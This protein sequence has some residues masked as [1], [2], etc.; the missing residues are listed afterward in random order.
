MLAD[1]AEG[2]RL[3][4]QQERLTRLPESGG[5]FRA[6]CRVRVEG[7]LTAPVL[8]GAV[9]KVVRRHEILRT[10]FA[11]L[12][13]MTLPLQ[14][15][16]EEAAFDLRVVDL[17]GR[18]P[19]G[20]EEALDELL[21]EVRSL[22][23]DR[24]RGPA[25]HVTLASLA[26][27]RHTL[28]FLLPALCADRMSMRN[29]V[30]EIAHTLQRADEKA[31]PVQYAD[32]A[33]AFANLLEAEETAAGR[34]FWR[35][36]ERPPEMDLGVGRLPGEGP[37]EKTWSFTPKPYFFAVGRRLWERL[38]DVAERFTA[39]REA[40]LVA[41]W[42]TLLWR[43]SGGD[44]ATVG[45]AFD[46]RTFAGLD[47]A[48]GLFTRDL[49]LVGDL[50]P[51]LAFETVVRRVAAGLA[52]LAE[53]QDFYA[54]E[55][56]GASDC[57]FELAAERAPLHAGERVFTLDCEEI[58]TGPF[59]LRLV[60]R[61]GILGLAAELWYDAG[62]FSSAEAERLAARWTRLLEGLVESPG[63]TIDEVE[64]VGEAERRW[65]LT[66]LNDTHVVWSGATGLHG[67]VAEQAER[68]PER[69]ALVCEGRNLS[70]GALAA[71]AR[72]L[73]GHLR[74]LGVLP[75]TK[76]GICLERSLEMVISLLAVLEAGGAYVPLDPD[77]PVER[78]AMIV[79]DSACP[80][81]IGD[82]PLT[83]R[84]PESGARTLFLERNRPAFAG[85]LVP[86]PVGPEIDPNALA[87][88][89]YTSGS[90]GKPKGV[91]V[92]HRAIVNRLRWMT[93]EFPLLA[94][95]RV[96]Q[97]TPF[98]FD[99][100]IWEIFSPLL[101]G[102]VA[103]LAR[104]GGHQETGYLAGLAAREEVT[105][106]QMVPPQLRVFLDEPAVE[107]CLALRRVFCGGDVLT[108]ALR[109]QC[110][111]R[112]GA[113][114]QNLYGPTEAAIDASFWVCRRGDTEAAVPIGRPLANVHLY[115]LDGR[116]EPVPFGIPGELYI[117]GTGLARGYLG[118]PD[119]TAERFLPDPFGVVPGGRLYSSGDFGRYRSDGALEFL[120]RGDGQVKIRGVRIEMGE[121]EA[122]LCRHPGVRAAVVL[123]REEI[124]GEKRLVA[125]VVPRA[126]AAPTA[127]EMRGFLRRVLPEAALPAQLVRLRAL[128]LLPNGKLDR[129]ALPV[130]EAAAGTLAVAP[131]TPVEDLLA[132]VWCE[133]LRLPA[134]GVEDNFFDLGGHSL[135]AT[136]LSSRLRHVLGVEVSMRQLFE[137][138]TVAELAILFEQTRRG[139]AQTVPPLRPGVRT[140]DVPLS[141]AQQRLWFL[142][143]LEP[144]NPAYNIPSALNAVGALDPVVLDAAFREVVRRHEVLRTS[145]PAAAGE[146]RQAV[147]AEQPLAL[148]V[149]DLRGLAERGRRDREA[150]RLTAEEAGL[151]F[152][153]ARGPLARVRLLRLAAEEQR[154]LVTLHHIVGDAW[155]STV[156]SRELATLY[157]AFAAGRPSPLPELP[158]QYADF[159]IWQREWLRGEVLEAQLR[160]WKERLD[161]APTLLE[162]PAD[163]PRPEVPSARGGH[164][165]L[166]LSRDLTDALKALGRRESV[167]LFMITLAAYRLLLHFATGRDDVVVGTD[168]ANRN[169][170]ETEGLIGFFINQLVLRTDLG[171]NPT[172]RELLAREREV[173]LDAYA[174][175]DL[176]FEK[177]IDL[178]NIDRNLKHPPLF[179][180]KLFFQNVPT[181]KVELPGLTLTSVATDSDAAKL[182][183][184]LAFWET[185]EGLVG[186]AN[187]S[188]D[189]FDGATIE[190]LLGQL[191]ALLAAMVA[192]PEARIGDLRRVYTGIEK[193]RLLMESDERLKFDLKQF[194]SIKPKA[195]NLG[196]GEPVERTSLPAGGSLPL[197]LRPVLADVDP[198]DWC[199]GHREEL[200]RDLK[201]HGAIL[202]R[203]FK[204]LT[205]DDFERLA[206]AFCS[207]LFNENGEHPRQSVSG[208]VYT[209]VFYPSDQRLLWHNENSFNQRWPRKILFCC[210]RPAAQ[211]G[212]TPLVDSREVYAQIPVEIREE[213]ERKGVLYLRTYGGG[214]GLGWQDV[215]QTESRQE[216]EE[217]CQADGIE[218]LWQPDGRLRT[219]AVRP[220]VLAHPETGEMS[221]F[222]QAQHWHV[223][224]LDP[225]TR[226]SMESLFAPDDLPRSC[227]FGDGTAIPDE[228]MHRIL[229]VYARLQVVFPWEKGDVVV[230]DN[231]LTAHG[232]NAFSGE[233]KI[234]VV[235]GD[236]ASFATAR[237]L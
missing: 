82:R 144:G 83:G 163:R 128:P 38:G 43:L 4:P 133:V 49:P 125:Y 33:E 132:G 164:R 45:V 1:V 34:E 112:L 23:L 9:E 148:P 179:Q 19:E 17:S 102:A 5:A 54:G 84:L 96:L 123:A 228:A 64:C 152:T 168:A 40:L 138:P 105:V 127:E 226:R 47:E 173:A 67:A 121:V 193:E 171:G 214:L 207:E 55:A 149:I 219:R 150:A 176:P 192:S 71:G 52:E 63:A 237:G 16:R 181:E 231:V 216:V 86:D 69:I 170:L 187:Y 191:Q 114:L 189:L 41:A 190:R 68:T 197:V 177:L 156:L 116:L 184:T 141:F 18:L 209:P 13:G 6:I 220:A 140:G 91:M 159:A 90:T 99:A 89:V 65:L 162:L 146:A 143:Q 124:P 113:D 155:S 104:P 199:Q 130:P 137:R 229:A 110:F 236:M 20:R 160:Y 165:Y 22:T 198:A 230:V 70:F 161:G 180:T 107:D 205:T 28:L 233:R 204:V 235:L 108:G 122:A 217:R 95:D 57:A 210:V 201:R 145:F 48:L 72:Q 188:R 227:R 14:V 183:L 56:I 93:R 126:G 36:Q 80:V 31:P 182:D 44:G 26:P 129:K 194:K 135:L 53:R 118:R 174:H 206:T 66:G 50:A 32:M 75:G 59:R 74:G 58:C 154:V 87:Y 119:L 7:P 225:E 139:E 11:T 2:F 103:V 88:V 21:R 203:G 81:L 35:R 195:V 15:I 158:I 178:L 222:N 186:W 61:P 142:D 46:G 175:E 3:S 232:R 92:S 10:T 172:V 77:H 136:K 24:E 79:E 212:E 134:I 202:L 62:R 215:F 151:P 131:R 169:R 25:L 166:R 221:W 200:A 42:Q 94:T 224:C 60:C 153:L 78:L 185:E 98:S 120:R 211:G 8:R 196:G 85:E 147:V 167:T 12:P 106:L 27:D 157:S 213:F 117:G 39:S 29:L 97:K 115:L 109:D 73:A 218:A 234:L 111:E 37:A 101:E 223:A 51:G 208:N 76:V 30:R 100:S